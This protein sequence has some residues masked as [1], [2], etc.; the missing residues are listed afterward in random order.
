MRKL[1]A[2]DEPQVGGDDVAGLEQHDVARHELGGRHGMTLASIADHA[3][4]QRRELLQRP[5]RLLGAVLLEEAER[6]VQ[7]HDG[8]D[9]DGVLDLA[10]EARDDARPRSAA[11]S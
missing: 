11:R 7:H 3:R 6:R 5:Q 4:L 8:E 2:G 1:R 9:G 10:D